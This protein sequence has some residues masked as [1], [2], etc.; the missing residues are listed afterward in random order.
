MMDR[1]K[2][3]KRARKEDPRKQVRVAEDATGKQARDG[4]KVYLEQMMSYQ[5]DED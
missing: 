5:Y 3:Q 2:G 4:N 1:K